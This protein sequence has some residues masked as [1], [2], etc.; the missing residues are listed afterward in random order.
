[1]I[2]I[3]KFCGFCIFDFHAK[4]T[5]IKNMGEI[6]TYQLTVKTQPMIGFSLF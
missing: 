2:D 3:F 4:Y 1:M 5:S 6:F